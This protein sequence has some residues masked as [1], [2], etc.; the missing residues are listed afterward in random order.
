[1]LADGVR[2]GMRGD[3]RPFGQLHELPEASLGQMRHIQ[4]DARRM[5]Y[6][7]QLPSPFRESPFRCSNAPS[8]AQF[9]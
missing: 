5:A 9:A 4:N 8:A 2:I 3:D 1:M 6:L 7:Y